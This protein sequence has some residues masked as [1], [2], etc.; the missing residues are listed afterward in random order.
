[1]QTKW[2]L[3]AHGSRDTKSCMCHALILLPSLH[4]AGGKLRPVHVLL[5]MDE[6]AAVWLDEASGNGCCRRR[7]GLVGDC[8]GSGVATSQGRQQGGTSLVV[9]MKQ[10]KASWHLHIIATTRRYI[11][12][13]SDAS[14]MI[15]STGLR[16]RPGRSDRWQCGPCQ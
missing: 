12:V 1:M 2:S 15:C 5:V 16:E 9:D 10:G 14:L 13:R 6:D 7:S 11:K 8:C 3:D 4:D